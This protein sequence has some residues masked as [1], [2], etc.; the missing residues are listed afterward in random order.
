[1]ASIRAYLWAAFRRGCPAIF[2][3]YRAARAVA[4]L[5]PARPRSRAATPLAQAARRPPHPQGAG[6]PPPTYTTAP[7]LSPVASQS[8]S[9]FAHSLAR[10]LPRLAGIAPCTCCGALRRL[11]LFRS[12]DGP[13]F[14]PSA[15]PSN[16]GN[17]TLLPRGEVIWVF[18]SLIQ[19]GRFREES[20][21]DLALVRR[22]P[23]FSE[24]W[25][26]GELELRLGRRVDVLLLD[27]T[28]LRPKI[29]REGI[30]GTL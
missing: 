7:S 20:D 13:L 25:L 4:Q 1:M 10:A 28:R 9:P 23:V 17:L 14:G 16:R 29:E 3:G 6:I 5:P 27:E 26:Q 22:P 15:C 11:N 24:F 8:A 19:S 21:V 18:G 30:K 12:L 2:L